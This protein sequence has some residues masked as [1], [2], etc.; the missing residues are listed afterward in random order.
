MHLSIFYPGGEGV[1]GILMGLDSQ[2]NNIEQ[3]CTGARDW[4]L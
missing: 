1:V 2:G 4:I 3:L